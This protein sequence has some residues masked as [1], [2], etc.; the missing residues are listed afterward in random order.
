MAGTYSEKIAR[1]AAAAIDEALD[2]DASGYRRIKLE[3]E[4]ERVITAHAAKCLADALAKIPGCRL[5]PF[6][7][8]ASRTSKQH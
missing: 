8:L 4:L 6:T 2:M 7:A 3:I 5:D 1:A